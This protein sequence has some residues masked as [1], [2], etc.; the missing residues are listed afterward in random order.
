MRRSRVRDPLSAPPRLCIV[1]QPTPRRIFVYCRE[2]IGDVV[3][4]TGSLLAL[5]SLYPDA[6][7]VVEAGERA[8]GLLH[9]FP[10]VDEV[11]SR[12]ERQ[13]VLGKVRATA[14]MRRSRFDWAL[15]FD[16]SNP[17]VL[18]AWLAGVPH[19]FGIWRGRKYR[20][21]YTG[22]VPYRTDVCETRD[23][24]EALLRLLGYDGPAPAPK[25]FPSDED[26]AEA[27]ALM[28]E[29]ARW[30][31]LHPGASL[32]EKRWPVERFADLAERIA[33]WGI[34]VGVL[35]GPSDRELADA[36]PAGVGL[37]G[38]CG[39]LASAALCQSAAALVT[40]DT[41]A[42]H[43]AAAMGTPVAA[44]FGP[45]DPVAYAPWGAGHCTLA[46]RDG[47][48]AAITVDEVEAVLRSTLGM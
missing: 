2:H 9:G 46:G 1:L 33:S 38:R 17:P 36:I 48:V 29:G 13:G 5:R 15:V 8:V 26:R 37:A 3:N 14:R 7:I 28:P 40:N 42:M 39:L 45:T 34:G 19:R 31:A 27:R 32:P 41:G 21:L 43:I 44:L 10:G 25:L 11:W 30:V 35:G 20:R 12:P 47:A 6:R 4:T 22:C 18:L 16:D 24:Q 23:N